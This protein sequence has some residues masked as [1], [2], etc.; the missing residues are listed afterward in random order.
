MFN[1]VPEKTDV[2][3][4][5]ISFFFFLK[6]GISFLNVHTYSRILPL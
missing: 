3:I 4:L 5:G 2:F 6:K 1:F